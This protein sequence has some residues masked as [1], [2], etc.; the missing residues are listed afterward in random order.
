MI[1]ASLC[2]RVARNLH[3]YMLHALIHHQNLL[4]AY[5]F[6]VYHIYQG[7]VVQSIVN[8]TSSLVVKMLIVL[9]REISNSQLFLLKKIE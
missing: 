6:H 2:G 1:L 5:V 8:L 7:Q 3:L 4:G 9:V